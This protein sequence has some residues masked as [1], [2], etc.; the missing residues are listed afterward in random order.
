M[1]HLLRTKRPRRGA[2]WV[3]PLLACAA[4]LGCGNA[5][6]DTDPV[7]GTSQP[8][9]G[10]TADVTHENVFLLARHTD[11]GSALCTATL[12]APNLLLTARHCVSPGTGED[13]VLCGDSVLGAPYPAEDFIATN[14]P[15]PRDNSLIFSAASV[16]VPG[17]GKDTCGFDIAL[18]TLSKSV[19]SSVSV[20]AVPRIDRE[21][22]PGE[23]YT[24]VGYGANES[25]SP[26]GRRM[27]RPGLTIACE[28]GSCGEGVEST[29]FRGETG[30]CSGDSGGPALDADGKVVGVVSRGGPDCSTPVYGT[31]TAWHD[32]LIETARTAATFGNYDPPFW[33]TSGSSDP[34]LLAGSAGANGTGD[35]T[36]GA[37]LGESCSPTTTCQDGLLCYAGNGASSGI[38][39]ATCSATSECSGGMVCQAAG[40]VS[41]CAR[42][43]KGADESGGC[44]LSGTKPAPAPLAYLLAFAGA[45]ALLLRK[46][47]DG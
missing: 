25:G 13:H 1:D 29:E 42:P 4:A 10:G 28:P 40:N 38:C 31:V 16:R 19:P 39:A 32:F 23:V 20:P 41:V 6:T 27:M 45:T 15:Q 34:P 22:Q 44:S 21:V 2:F 7:A 36:T 35:E 3:A 24:A 30:I 47:R 37:A 43:S 11:Q 5:G 9:A 14:D 33:V 46:R 26:T 17:L 18:I 8:I 12:I